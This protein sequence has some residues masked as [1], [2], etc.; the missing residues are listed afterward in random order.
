[1]NNKKSRLFLW[2]SLAF[3][4]LSVVAIIV[5]II[6]S[7]YHIK[8]DFPNDPDMIMNEFAFSLFV[9]MLIIFPVFAVELSFIRS[10]YKLI[11]NEPKGYVKVCYIIS[12]VLAFIAF[13][14]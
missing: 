14:Y 2:V 11:K 4:V 3:F 13:T 9:S 6:V 7:Y 10:V 5:C 12:S 1:M 8:A